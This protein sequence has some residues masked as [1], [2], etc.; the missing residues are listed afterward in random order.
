MSAMPPDNNESMNLGGS[1]AGV[2]ETPRDLMNADMSATTRQQ[3]SSQQRMRR[4]K[5]KIF[6]RA[7]CNGDE[8][9]PEEEERGR[10]LQ[11]ARIK[12]NKKQRERYRQTAEEERK[13]KIAEEERKLK[14]VYL[15]VTRIKKNKK[16]CEPVTNVCEGEKGEAL[17]V[18]ALCC[19]DG[20][21][22]QVRSGGVCSRHGA[23]QT[24]TCNKKGCTNQAQLRGV[25]VAHGAKTKCCSHVE[26][27]KQVVREGKCKD[28]AGPA[29]TFHGSCSIESCHNI[30]ILVK[31]NKVLVCKRYPC[32]SHSGKG[33]RC[34]AK[35]CPKY[36]K[37]LQQGKMRQMMCVFHCDMV[38][39]RCIHQGCVNDALQGGVCYFHGANTKLCCYDIRLFNEST[40]EWKVSP[41]NNYARKGGFCN[42]HGATKPLPTCRCH[43]CT[44]KCRNGDI[45]NGCY[46]ESL[47]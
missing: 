25:C 23:K 1:G 34:S 46:I 33:V 6:L 41:C 11:L 5:N 24:R 32:M 16:Q 31:V 29:E 14:N 43:G 15:T 21:N 20:C 45:C 40:K 9:T 35:G 28:H 17:K 3:M 42:R 12:K 7:Y 39:K 36:V 27:T 8:M 4:L 18:K 37:P 30:G 47:I 13:L 44:N 38:P 22:N 2:L 26:C 10:R 19:F